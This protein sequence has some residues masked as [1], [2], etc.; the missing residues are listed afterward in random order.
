MQP[1]ECKLC[2]HNIYLFAFVSSL[3]HHN[4]KCDPKHVR[5]FAT[6][7]LCLNSSWIKT[8]GRAHEVLRRAMMSVQTQNH[9]D[10]VTWHDSKIPP[11]T[12]SKTVNGNA[13][14]QNSNQL[15]MDFGCMVLRCFNTNRMVCNETIWYDEG[16]VNMLI[17]VLYGITFHHGQ[18]CK[19]IGCS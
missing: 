3:L 11:Q 16:N 9:S 7:P 1:C 6:E 15:Q 10:R 12:W 5:Q 19:A 2:Y 17:Y 13:K 8:W 18:G 4:E 14:Q